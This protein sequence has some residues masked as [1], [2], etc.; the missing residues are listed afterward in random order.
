MWHRLPACEHSNSGWKP[1]PHRSRRKL[2]PWSCNQPCDETIMKSDGTRTICCWVTLGLLV[3]AGLSTARA[4]TTIVPSAVPPSVVVERQLWLVDTRAASS[5]HASVQQARCLTYWRLDAGRQWCSSVLPEL[6]GTDNPAIPTLIYVHENRVTRSESFQR[7]CSVFKNLSCRVPAG[8]S[9][10]MIAV[11]W[12]SDRIGLLPR[13]DAKIKAKRSEA[14]GLYLAWLTDQIHPDVSIGMFGMSYGPRLITAAL[15]HLGGG[16]IEGRCLRARVNPVRQPVRIALAAAALDAH[17]L[18]TGQ[19]HGQALTQVEHAFLMV[20]PKDQVLR[21]YPRMDGIGRRGPQ[22]LGYVGVGAQRGC[23]F[24]PDRV[25]ECNVSGQIAGSHR[26][27][28][29]EGSPNMMAKMVN[30]L[31]D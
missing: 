29:Y 7:A 20:N 6:L 17:W 16:S 8:Q 5:N 28:D 21:L 14:H 24:D 30:H 18:Q 3:L 27:T 1:M 26:W 23:L 10:R 15:H 19:R 12:P 31:V 4:D 22:A 9:F 25:T 11:S 2:S 13:P